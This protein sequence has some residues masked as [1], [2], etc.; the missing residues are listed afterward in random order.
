MSTTHTLISVPTLIALLPS[1]PTN[2]KR[3]YASEIDRLSQRTYS[4]SLVGVVG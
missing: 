4:F 1:T 2:Q 3:L